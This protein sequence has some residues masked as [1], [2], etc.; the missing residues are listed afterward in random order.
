MTDFERVEKAAASREAR[1]AIG[2]P[3]GGTSDVSTVDAALLR[4]LGAR[5]YRERVAETREA[6]D[7]DVRAPRSEQAPGTA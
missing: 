2:H 5:E 4:Y 6:E 3:R 7:E 1:A